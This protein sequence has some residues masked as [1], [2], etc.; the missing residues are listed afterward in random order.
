MRTVID[1]GGRGEYACVPA[2]NTTKPTIIAA[3]AAKFNVA[4]P[5]VAKKG[6]KISVRAAALD[7]CDNLACPSPTG[8]IFLSEM[9]DPYT[10]LATAKLKPEDKGC[11]EMEVDIP[12]AV[13]SYRVVLS[14]RRDNLNG[15]T[16]ATVV[17]NRPETMRVYFG[18]IHAKTKLSDGL[19]TPLEY[20]EH[21]R[22]VALMDFG[23]IADHNAEETSRIEGPYRTQMSDEAFAEIQSACE[24][25]NQAGR[26]VTLQ[27]FEQNDIAGYPGHRNIY[28]RDNCPGLFRGASLEELYSY[29]QGHDALV[30]PHHPIIWKT[31][32]HLDNQNYERVLELYSM[33]CS[34]EERGGPINNF[35][36]TLNKAESGIS[37]REVLDRGYRVGFIAASDNH[38]GAPGLSARP[39]RF[40]NLV[41]RGGLAA[42][43][44]PSLTRENIFDGLY[45][46]RC[47]ATTGNRLYMDWR[48]NGNLMGSEI[49]LEAGQTIH[50]NLIIS[51]SEAIAK[52]ELIFSEKTEEIFRYSGKDL[53]RL[54]G[55]LTFQTDTW[56]YVRITQTDRHMAWS[57]PVWINILENPKKN[58]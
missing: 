26:F 34:S 49:S 15:V 57:S 24:A 33:H 27:G 55:D 12:D 50:Y 20:F 48:I 17:D 19:K 14:N 25:Y 10:P 32:V 42:V 38:N 11:I 21:A 53:L 35:A 51:A 40:T 6:E 43:L 5:A 31:R 54:E 23:A 16:A 18:D 58:L 9:D 7:F 56:V 41:Y 52:V 1:L 4:V 39:S 36:T 45:N 44:A 46:R 47:Y 22:D 13:T 30:I 2:K 3:P 8:D 29:L 37:A 28:F